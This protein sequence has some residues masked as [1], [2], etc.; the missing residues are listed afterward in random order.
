MRS[1]FHQ[2]MLY[3]CM[4]F[5]EITQN[6]SAARTSFIQNQNQEK[7]LHCDLLNFIKYIT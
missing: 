1:G 5:S 7:A 3:E 4:R 2:N 6:H